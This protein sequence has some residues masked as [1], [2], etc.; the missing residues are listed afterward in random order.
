MVRG[1]TPAGR[2]VPWHCPDGELLRKEVTLSTT[3]RLGFCPLTRWIGDV[4]V[5]RY[6][7]L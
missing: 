7:F 2:E 4:R 3:L 6:L 1:D 5:V